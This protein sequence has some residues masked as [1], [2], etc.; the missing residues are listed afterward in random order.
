MGQNLRQLSLRS[1]SIQISGSKLLLILE[2]VGFKKRFERTEGFGMADSVRERVPGRG[3][4][5]R[6]GTLPLCPLAA[7]GDAEKASVGRGAK[8]PRRGVESEEV[9]EVWR[10]RVSYNLIAKDR[11]LVKNSVFDSEPV[12]IRQKGSNMISDRGLVDKAS[13]TV[14]YS[15]EFVYQFLWKSSQQGIAVV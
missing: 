2:K 11:G 5:I 10:S 6:K 8:L 12:K 1:R 9:G 4:K 14:H 15:L 7:T 13:S 3:A